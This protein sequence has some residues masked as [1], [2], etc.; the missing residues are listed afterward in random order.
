[1]ATQQWGSHVPKARPKAKPRGY[2]EGGPVDPGG[3]RVS[4]DTLQMDLRSLA[5]RKRPG[6]NRDEY[7]NLTSD[8]PQTE[9]HLRKMES[10]GAMLSGDENERSIRSGEDPYTQMRYSAPED[11]ARYH[12]FAKGGPVKKKY[13]GSPLDIKRDKAGAKKMGLSMKAY[14]KTPQDRAQDAKGQRQMYGKRK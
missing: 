1:M 11:R 4:K 10:L 8:D 5:E 13:E 6:G 3:K 7:P 14:E 2:A 9:R 12:G